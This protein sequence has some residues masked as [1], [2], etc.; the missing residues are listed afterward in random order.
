MGGGRKIYHVD[1][2]W[3][4][5]SGT[6][7]QAVTDY[8]NLIYYRDPAGIYVNL[9]IPSR[10]TWNQKGNLITVEQETAYPESDT[11]RITVRP[12]KPA[13]FDLKFRVPLWSRGVSV[14]VN[15]SRLDLSGA[16]GTWAVVRRTWAAGDRLT[17]HIPL[18]L[19]LSPVDSQH[20]Q[21]V[22]VM[23]GPVVLVRRE[24]PALILQGSGELSSQLRPTGRPLE[25]AAAGQPHGEFVPFYAVGAESPY[26]MYFDLKES[27]TG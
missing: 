7:P 3:P 10:A 19:R 27:R 15:D 11:T 4:C 13:A 17:I 16:P 1:G 14:E 2:R 12:G 8:H 5:C 25:F 9:F 20:P 24:S 23:C 6:Y 18:E 26:N 22:A 21:R